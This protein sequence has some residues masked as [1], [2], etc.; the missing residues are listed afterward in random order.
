MN[1]LQGRPRQPIDRVR[2]RPGDLGIGVVFQDE[3]QRELVERARRKRALCRQQPHVTRDLA[4]TEEIHQRGAKT[5]I[6]GRRA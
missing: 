3:Q 5:G 1:R 6:H 4:A 2:R